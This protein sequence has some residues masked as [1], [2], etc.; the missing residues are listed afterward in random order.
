MN[1][2]K[3]WSGFKKYFQLYIMKLIR[4][5]V[6]TAAWAWRAVLAIFHFLNV[7]ED[8]VNPPRLSATKLAM[9]GAM[10]VG[11]WLLAKVTISGEPITFTDAGLVSILTL[12][13][14]VLKWRRDQQDERDG[15]GRWGGCGGGYGGRSGVGDDD[16]IDREGQ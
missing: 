5:F 6:A 10:A 9:W 16:P 12:A 3:L 14:S 2:K 1:R 8:E 11:L 4:A 15:R 13:A 7:L